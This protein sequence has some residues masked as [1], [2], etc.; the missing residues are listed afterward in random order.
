M[1][2]VLLVADRTAVF[3]GLRAV[4]A[5]R[6]WAL[7]TAQDAAT[8]VAVAR[9]T[10]PDVIVSALDIGGA[11]A[12]LLR[13][14]RN[15]PGLPAQRVVQCLRTR[16]AAA[17]RR[18]RTLGA[19]AVLA[20]PASTGLIMAAMAEAVMRGAT[21]TPP[22][23]AGAGD[24][25]WRA[26]F[27]A[28]PECVK[29]VDAT[30]RLVDMNPAGLAMLEVSSLEEAQRYELLHYILPQYRASF[31][32]LHRRVMRGDTGLLEFE[33]E[34]LRGA[35]RWLETH[36]TPLRDIH[37]NIEALLGITHDITARRRNEHALRER[38]AQLY[39]AQKL[40]SVG[41]LAAGIAHDF[42]N[43]LTVVN[44]TAD[45]LI[46]R[47]PPESDM[48]DDARAIREAATQAAGL[49]RQLL[50]ISRKQELKPEVVDLNRLVSD[51]Q[52]LLQRALGRDVELMVRRPAGPVEAV[53][54]PA[55][56]QQV[57]VNLA[58]NSRDAMPGG[59]TL[60]IETAVQLVNGE[61][62]PHPRLRPGPYAVLALS[63]TGTGMDDGTLRQAFEPF[64]TTKPAGVG[65]GLGLSIVQGIVTQSGGEVALR[66]APNEGTTVTIYLPHAHAGSPS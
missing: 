14:C 24:G 61:M 19:D 42:N 54:D 55:Q 23:P 38:E 53:V 12:D 44:S 9:R 58:V 18:A 5:R 45:L 41:R 26:V 49:T 6:R 25:R 32:E 3:R 43:M 63:D 16:S 60:T 50:A 2:R 22:A 39:H 62:P 52:A 65:T 30:G 36:A 37:G 35:R 46:E 48:S 57:V 51:T 56:L 27:D 10:S 17:I 34:G 8:A 59:G 11:G 40:E 31:V 28:E 13:L 33:I 21:W 15:E 20:L 4:L 64:F 7:D 47:L 29:I 1:P 66:S